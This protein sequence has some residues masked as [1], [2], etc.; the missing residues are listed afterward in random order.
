MRESTDLGAAPPVRSLKPG[1]FSWFLKTQLTLGRHEGQGKDN[2]NQGVNAQAEVLTEALEILKKFTTIA[3]VPGRT[4]E[5]SVNV[6]WTKI[7]HCER[8][9][10]HMDSHNP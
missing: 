10:D 7:D 5:R 3:Q 6:P 2:V 1:A 8:H 9:K 4:S